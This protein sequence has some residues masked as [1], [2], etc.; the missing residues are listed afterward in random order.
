MSRVLLPGLSARELLI[1]RG[2]TILLVGK[3]GT[4]KSTLAEWL[5]RDAE[6]AIVYST[7]GDPREDTAW[8]RCGYE[9]V[10]DVRRLPQ[11]ARA[12]LVAGPELLADEGR[13]GAALAHPLERVPTMLLF[14]EVHEVFPAQGTHPA[15]RKLLHQA[16]S[17]G[18]VLIICS[19]MANGID[20]RLLRLAHHIVV[21]GKAAHADDL[22][23]LERATGVGTRVLSRLQRR[24]VAW[25]NHEIEGWRVFHPIDPQGPQA[26]QPLTTPESWPYP[27]VATTRRRWF[28]HVPIPT[29][30]VALRIMADPV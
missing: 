30:G 19:Q 4:G 7:K 24:Q 8:Q 18:H 21:L 2:E 12:L 10:D 28:R 5:M 3:P 26:L 29:P 11:H 23:Y 9:R 20:T 1:R 22:R 13:W 14:D 16:R 6:S 17:W 27:A 25:W 15:A